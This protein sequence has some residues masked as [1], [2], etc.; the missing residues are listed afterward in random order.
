MMGDL[1]A[2]VFCGIVNARLADG[3]NGIAILPCEMVVAGVLLFQIH[4]T[5]ALYL[6]NHLG[7]GYLARQHKKCMYV[8]TGTTH[9]DG[10]TSKFVDGSADIGM[11]ML[12]ILPG[13]S[14]ARRFDMEDEMDI[15][16]TQ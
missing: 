9:D 4:S 10:G 1:V 15:Y 16:F 13:Y 7:Y 6:L 11:Q 5:V 3:E 14:R 12:G 8:V 2:D